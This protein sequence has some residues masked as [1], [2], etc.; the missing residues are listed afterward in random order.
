MYVNWCDTLH[1]VLVIFTGAFVA[2][3]LISERNFRYWNK[4]P[5]FVRNSGSVTDFKKNLEFFRSNCV[6]IDCGNFWEVTYLVMEKIEVV[7]YIK[8]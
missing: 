3:S 5:A 7:N 6:E 4:L 1:H 2:N 8:N